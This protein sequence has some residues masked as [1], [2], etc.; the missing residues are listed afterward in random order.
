MASTPS[1]RRFASVRLTRPF[2]FRY[3][4]LWVMLSVLMILVVAVTSYLLH[5]KHWDSLVSLAPE[6][7]AHR[8]DAHARFLLILLVQSGLLLG[9]VLLLAMM[10]THRLAG[11]IVGLRLA[12]EDVAKGQLGRRVGF[13]SANDELDELASAFNR[14]MDTIEARLGPAGGAAAGGRDHAQG[15]VA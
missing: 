15:P 1:T 5:V 13:R 9:A 12:C 10:T 2:I 7:A 8:P 3:S 14:M 4:G 11:P 6:L